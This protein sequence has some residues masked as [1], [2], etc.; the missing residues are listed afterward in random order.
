MKRQSAAKPEVIH[1]PYGKKATKK[2][3]ESFMESSET[4]EKML[5]KHNLVE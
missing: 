3:F 4:I 1:L 5:I 2:D